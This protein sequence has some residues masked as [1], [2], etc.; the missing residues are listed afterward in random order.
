M[1]N[2]S[3]YPPLLYLSF[4]SML[5][6]LTTICLYLLLSRLSFTFFPDYPPTVISS[7]LRMSLRLLEHF[8]RVLS[9]SLSPSLCLSL[10]F[11]EQTLSISDILFSQG[12]DIVLC[13]APTKLMS[14]SYQPPFFHSRLSRCIT[15]PRF[16]LLVLFQKRIFHESSLAQYCNI[17]SFTQKKMQ[18]EENMWLP[19]WC[20]LLI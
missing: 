8:P 6:C 7:G 5:R 19:Q 1:F 16:P 12:K 11:E 17:L 15:T 20:Y 18:C 10:S 2:G 14:V 13:P 9:L 4:C 3:L